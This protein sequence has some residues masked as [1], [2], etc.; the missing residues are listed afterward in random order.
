MVAASAQATQRRRTTTSI[1][2]ILHAIGG[3]LGSAFA[4]WLL[5]PLERARIE[6]QRSSASSHN[7]TAAGT[8]SVDNDDDDEVFEE[9]EEESWQDAMTETSGIAK[10]ENRD[11]ETLIVPCSQS[12]NEE[13]IWDCIRRLYKE[14]VL[15]KGSSTIVFTVGVSNFVFFYCNEFLKQQ[16]V[17]KVPSHQNKHIKL[18]PSR[19]L[20][21]SCLAGIFNVCITNPFWVA[22]M[23]LIQSNDARSSLSSE[24]TLIVR[25]H[26]WRHLWAGTGASLLLVSNPILQFFVYEQLKPL[27]PTALQAFATGAVAKVVATVATYPLQLSQTLLRSET[28]Y[29]NTMDCLLT[30]YG[31][32]GC[33]AL[34][35]GMKAKMLQTVLT[36]AFTFLTYEQIVSVLASALTTLHP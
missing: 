13:V 15:Y 14:N 6:L 2:P 26:G 12:N 28:T 22:N 33:R 27:Q 32:N 24:L 11:G 3:S 35:R 17:S 7:E 5:Y 36:A 20:L 18:T 4:L 1:P 16:L 8:H 10:M 19:A 23:N 31:H 25:D 9:A 21:A 30:L 34:F 29:K